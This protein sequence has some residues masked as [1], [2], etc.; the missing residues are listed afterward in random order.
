MCA[1]Q[2]ADTGGL[3]DIGTPPVVAAQE[4]GHLIAQPA[5]V[6]VDCLSPGGGADTG[7]AS[8]MPI[9]CHSLGHHG[10]SSRSSRQTL[11]SG[12]K[13]MGRLVGACCVEGLLEQLHQQSLIT[14]PIQVVQHNTTS[15]VVDAF[16]AAA[17][18]NSSADDGLL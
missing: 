9:T 16:V 17:L 13:Q 5:G 15:S 6:L 12:Y 8:P 14:G 2:V 18:A 3:A 4:E 1:L 10:D 7:T 11:L